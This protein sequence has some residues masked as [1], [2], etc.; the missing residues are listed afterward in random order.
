MKA[1]CIFPL[2]LI[3]CLSCSQS[4]P[5]ADQY[6]GTYRIIKVRE[7]GKIL[8]I[9][10]EAK[11]G[12]NEE[13]YVS[14][15]DRNGDHQISEDEVS[16]VVYTFHVDDEGNPYLII[17]NDDTPVEILKE[18]HFDLLLRKIDKLGNESIFYLK[19]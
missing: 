14:A 16:S 3:S 15:I 5:R 7:N 6:F 12:I 9:D 10:T 18:Q 19:K 2:I 4:A 17:N 13:L 1:L 8:N 11:I